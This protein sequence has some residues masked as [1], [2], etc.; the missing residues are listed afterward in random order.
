[1]DLESW[2]SVTPEAIAKQIAA[3]AKSVFSPPPY[4]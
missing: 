2:Y 3:R 1:M 4:L